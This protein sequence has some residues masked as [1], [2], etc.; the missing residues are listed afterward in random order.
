MSRHSSLQPQPLAPRPS[1][2]RLISRFKITCALRAL[3]SPVAAIVLL[4]SYLVHVHVQSTRACGVCVRCA[5]A[6]GHQP[7]DGGRA[8]RERT[9]LLPRH[10]HLCRRVRQG[11]L[12]RTCSSCSTPT[13]HCTLHTPSLFAQP[14]FVAHCCLCTLILHLRSYEYCLFYAP[15]ASTLHPSRSRTHVRCTCLQKTLAP[16]PL[17]LF[18]HP[19]QHV[20]I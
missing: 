1:P 9:G 6:A 4:I 10:G 3:S 14:L 15:R 2:G 8:G 20:Q 19:F 5:G 16:A 17:P 11:I 13:S 18:L 12:V 7:V